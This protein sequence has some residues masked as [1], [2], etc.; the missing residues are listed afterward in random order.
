M[1]KSEQDKLGRFWVHGILAR[2]LSR[3]LTIQQDLV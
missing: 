1:N 3:D 2:G